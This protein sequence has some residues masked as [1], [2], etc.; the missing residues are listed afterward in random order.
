LGEKT[1][2][3]RGGKK[4]EGYPEGRI[5]LSREE[6]ALGK[7]KTPVYPLQRGRRSHSTKKAPSFYR[8]EKEKK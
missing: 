8:L 4:Q 1:R 2:V 7:K 3:E 6:R 5:S